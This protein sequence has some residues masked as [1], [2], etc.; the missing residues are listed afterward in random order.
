MGT[1]LQRVL[2]LE[3]V[4][5]NAQLA[6]FALET[7]SGLEVK[8]ARDGNQAIELFQVWKPDVCLFDY[9]MPLKSGLDVMQELLETHPAARQIPFVFLTAR[10]DLTNARMLKAAGARAVIPKPFDIMLLGSQLAD[11]YQGAALPQRR[12]RAIG[13]LSLVESVAKPVAK[14]SVPPAFIGPQCE[15]QRVVRQASSL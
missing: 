1:P 9:L 5:A 8:H 15:P 6:C 7:I 4:E 13:R 11:I 2:L 10:T 3:D 14:A 12:E